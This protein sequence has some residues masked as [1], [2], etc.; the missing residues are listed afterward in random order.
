MSKQ[1]G[2]QASKS[3]IEQFG[4]ASKLGHL[5]RQAI[6]H[7]QDVLRRPVL[8]GATGVAAFAGAARLVVP[9]IAS[10]REVIAT[11]SASDS[12]GSVIASVK[13]AFPRQKKSSE[14]TRGGK[15]HKGVSRMFGLTQA[16]QL[17][18]VKSYEKGN[19]QY[20]KAFYND[21]ITNPGDQL[22]VGLSDIEV[23]P[24]AG[25]SVT[26]STVQTTRFYNTKTHSLSSINQRTYKYPLNEFGK[27]RVYKDPTEPLTPGEVINV[28]VHTLIKDKNPLA[29]SPEVQTNKIL[30]QV[31][32]YPI[33]NNLSGLASSATTETTHLT[34]TER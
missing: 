11:T 5:G 26:S 21:E 14:Y 34:T 27:K 15:T 23:K 13:S 25:Q 33:A 30:F 29:T 8:L 3:K 12:T 6:R 31:D 24:Y 7:T 10:G 22:T 1:Q 17:E 32:G 18:F 20:I 28:E 9:T 16:I 2:E 4:F 19:E